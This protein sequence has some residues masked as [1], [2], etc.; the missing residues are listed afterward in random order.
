MAGSRVGRLMVEWTGFS[1]VSS[2]ALTRV[3]WV[4]RTQGTLSTALALATH[5]RILAAACFEDE[6]GG[7]RVR[8][9]RG[10]VMRAASQRWNSGLLASSCTLVKV[11]AERGGGRSAET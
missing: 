10:E 4:S 6:G 7:E 5:S 9:G 1:D 8:G 3:D 2:A 11:V